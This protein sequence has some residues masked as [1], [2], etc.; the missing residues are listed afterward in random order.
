MYLMGQALFGAKL[1]EQKLSTSAI[2][3][4]A[5]SEK[6]DCILRPILKEIGEKAGVE[7]EVV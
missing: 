1:V 5:L 6:D 4:V 7:M 3:S 2:R